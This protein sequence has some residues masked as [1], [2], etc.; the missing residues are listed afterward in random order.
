MLKY[1]KLEINRIIKFFMQKSKIFQMRGVFFCGMFLAVVF[2]LTNNSQ[3]ANFPLEIINI[4][5]A[6][7]G[8]PA[9]PATNRIFRAYPGIEYNIRAAV[10]GGTYPYTY[11]LSNA[12]EGMTIN[13]R[14]GEIIWPNPQSDASDIQLSVKDSENTT[15]STTWSITVSI[16]GFLFVDAAYSGVETGS[17]T[18]PFSSIENMI[19][20]TNSGDSQD[21]VYFRGGNYILIEHNNHFRATGDVTGKYGFNLSYGSGDNLKPHKWIGY[22]GEIV[23]IDGDGRY[24]EIGSIYFDNL[25]LSNF[26]DW[27]LIVISQNHYNVVRRCNWSTLYQVRD[28]NSNQGFYFHMETNATYYHVFQDNTF[29]DYNGAQAIGSLYRTHKMLIEN[30]YM[31]DGGYSVYHGFAQ[32]VGAK[33]NTDYLTIRG[34]KIIMP[35]SIPLDIYKGSDNVDICFN[36]LKQTS[37]GRPLYF[38]ANNTFPGTV[39][40]YRNTIVGGNINIRENPCGSTLHGPY[41]FYKN[42]FI[43]EGNELYKYNPCYRVCQ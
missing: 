24:I 38:S 11:S 1:S 28:T 37:G 22:P 2:G 9:I 32:G 30:N 43:L 7:T 12:P 27:G 20:K 41:N 25:N 26:S 29:R 16:N 42:I 36:F 17:I 5:P 33:Y 3:A 23:N 15:V 35:A 31:S 40:V 18:Q 39:N 6:G 19:N 21:I 14:T 34:N 8:T 10:I 4:K 13:S